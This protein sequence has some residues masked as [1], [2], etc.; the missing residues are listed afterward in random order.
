MA[1]ANDLESYVGMQEL[2]VGKM[3]QTINL[4]PANMFDFEDVDKV[5]LLL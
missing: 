1:S 5:D 4:F 3:A 2:F